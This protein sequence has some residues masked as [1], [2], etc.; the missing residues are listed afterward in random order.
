MFYLKA[1]PRCRGDIHFNSDVYGDYYQCLQC[2]RYFQ[3]KI[4]EYQWEYGV[5]GG[6]KSA[7][8]L[9]AQSA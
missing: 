7:L 5:F 6:L 3:P 9:Q 2:G 1:C 8:T 4:L